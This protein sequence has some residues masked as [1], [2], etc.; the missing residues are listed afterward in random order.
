M[1]RGRMRA[2]AALKGQP[3]CDS[4]FISGRGGRAGCTHVDHSSPEG[5][6]I[7]EHADAQARELLPGSEEYAAR[8]GEA[9]A[10]LNGQPPWE[11]A[12]IPAAEEGEALQRWLGCGAADARERLAQVR[13]GDLA[14]DERM[15][16]AAELRPLLGQV[17][18]QLT[19]CN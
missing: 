4:A 7:L 5:P 9:A 11:P 14:G 10:A 18:L 6:T 16:A 3:I 12:R 1:Q 13:R 17:G 8:A 15:L 2:A 19:L